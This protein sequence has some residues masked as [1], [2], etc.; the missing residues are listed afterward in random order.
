MGENPWQVHS[1]QEFSCLKCPECSFDTKKEDFFQNHATENHPLSY[2]LFTKPF[3]EENCLEDPLMS[4]DY[5]PDIEENSETQSEEDIFMTIDETVTKI[6]DLANIEAV[7]EVKNE[8][9][10]LQDSHNLGIHED[11]N[12]DYLTIKYKRIEEFFI[13]ESSETKEN[14][15]IDMEFSCV[16]CLP[17]RKVLKTTSQGPI[18]NLKRHLIKMHPDLIDRFKALLGCKQKQK[19]KYCDYTSTRKSCITKHETKCVK[20]HI[21]IVHDKITP[22]LCAICD[23]KCNMKQVLENHISAVHEGKKPHVCSQC[24]KSFGHMNTLRRHIACVHEGKK[25]CQCNDCGTMFSEKRALKLHIITVH[26]GKKLNKCPKCDKSFGLKENL[27]KHIRTVHEGIKAFQ[28][29]LCGSKFSQKA[30]VKD[31]IAE[32]HEKKSFQT[33]TLCQK[34]FSKMSNLK[35][36]ITTVHEG[37]KYI[38]KEKKTVSVV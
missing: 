5:R 26:E 34:T 15:I 14:G 7:H 33:C 22:F 36:H 28:C 1:I 25:S 11:V 35:F 31:H 6:E 3:K 37:K 30:S 16:N 21:E 24:G 23:Y 32:V 2:V 10:N 17:V 13:F 8:A 18:S 38:R 29:D 9:V 20:A 4:E 27:K 12:F 19:C